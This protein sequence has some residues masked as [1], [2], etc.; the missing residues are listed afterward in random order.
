MIPMIGNPS[1]KKWKFD[2]GET[3]AM[4]LACER[5][6]ELSLN[7]PLLSIFEIY[8]TTI[9]LSSSVAL[10]FQKMMAGSPTVS[11]TKQDTNII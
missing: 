1:A 4:A 5:F 10:P 7:C 11:K 2:K 9:H 8:E 3:T 6:E